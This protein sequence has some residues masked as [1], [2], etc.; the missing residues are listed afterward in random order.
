MGREVALA[1]VAAV[2]R[3][4]CG[5]VFGLALTDATIAELG[6]GADRAVDRPTT[7]GATL[8]VSGALVGRR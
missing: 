3:E 8:S 5:D 2:V 4:A 7:A 6:L 1:A